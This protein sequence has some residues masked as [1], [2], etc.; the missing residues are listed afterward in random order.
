MAAYVYIPGD[1]TKSFAKVMADGSVVYNS[2]AYRLVNGVYTKIQSFPDV[3][4][5]MASGFQR[6]VRLAKASID[7]G[8]VISDYPVVQNASGDFIVGE[9]FVV[10]VRYLVASGER[11]LTQADALL[12]K[13]ITSVPAWQFTSTLPDTFPAGTP[14]SSFHPLYMKANIYLQK[15][16]GSIDDSALMAT[17]SQ[18]SNMPW[19]IP[20]GSS[21][22]QA[23]IA[24]W[25]GHTPEILDI[26]SGTTKIGSN[27]VMVD[28]LKT[29]VNMTVGLSP[30]LLRPSQSPPAPMSTISRR[31]T[32]LSSTVRQMRVA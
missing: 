24:D 4:T 16:I 30:I 5:Q 31:C 20:A 10:A 28:A 22:A 13:C 19:S 18:G 21:S 3:I 12:A 6:E 7:D 14:S 9:N 1:E 2:A 17:V 15:T 8:K 29:A 32:S 23:A 27:T 25:T 26:S 11:T